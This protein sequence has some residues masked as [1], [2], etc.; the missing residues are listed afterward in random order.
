MYLV[1]LHTWDVFRVG[2]KQKYWKAFVNTHET[3]D[4]ILW[5]FKEMQEQLVS[6]P[7]YCLFML[8]LV[9]VS[10]S[11]LPWITPWLFLCKVHDSSCWFPFSPCQWAGF[12]VTTASTDRKSHLDTAWI[13][14][15]I[16]EC[17][18][19]C[20]NLCDGRSRRT[21]TY[22][23]SYPSF[24]IS[25]FSLAFFLAKQTHGRRNSQA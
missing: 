17:S 1:H 19:W 3:W 4:V 14:E 5:L 11:I 13:S 9:Q 7:V 25:T 6:V 10:S 15:C 23:A 2:I 8:S 12:G 21:L 24:V 20:L 16:K 22:A 18:H